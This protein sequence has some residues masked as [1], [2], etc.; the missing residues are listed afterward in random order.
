MFP[1]LILRSTE[2]FSFLSPV[3]NFFPL[4]SLGSEKILGIL[5]FQ[6]IRSRCAFVYISDKHIYFF[7]GC[8]CH[9]THLFW[10]FQI[11]RFTFISSNIYYRIWQVI[12]TYFSSFWY[13]KSWQV[14]TR[15]HEV[16]IITKHGRIIAVPG[17][18]SKI[19]QNCYSSWQEEHTVARAMIS[20]RS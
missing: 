9:P 16:S 1:R 11:F 15:N 17:W 5:Q 3:Y 18:Y 6:M 2:I 14:V 19:L 10:M 8:V 4:K 20:I 12:M 7:F 13:F